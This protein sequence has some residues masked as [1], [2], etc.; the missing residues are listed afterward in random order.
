MQSTFEC[1]QFKNRAIILKHVGKLDSE[2]IWRGSLN[3][4]LTIFT[5]FT[6]SVLISSLF[7]FANYTI[8][9]SKKSSS[10]GKKKLWPREDRVLLYLFT[11]LGV[12]KQIYCPQTERSPV[13]CSWAR[14]F[15]RNSPPG[16]LSARAQGCREQRATGKD[17]V[18]QGAKRETLGRWEAKV[19]L[20]R[21]SSGSREAGGGNHSRH[22]CG[23]SCPRKS[24]RRSGAWAR[25]T[26]PRVEPRCWTAPRPGTP[27]TARWPCGLP[28]RSPSP[29]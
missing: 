16:E 22:M 24:S 29:P 9:M 11:C 7:F 26:A 6:V 12:C 15:L 5:S 23:S 13:V 14:R 4:Y 3:L 25:C 27:R 10:C 2:Q 1:L 8:V 18:R 20:Y 28:Q 21:G 19:G 17:Y